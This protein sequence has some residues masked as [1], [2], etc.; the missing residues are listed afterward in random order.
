M[1]FRQRQGLEPVKLSMIESR[2]A[3]DEAHQGAQPLPQRVIL[4][5]PAIIQYGGFM[6]LDPPLPCVLGELGAQACL[7]DAGQTTQVGHVSCPMGAGGCQR[8]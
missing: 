4:G 7:A 2:T 5:T 1:R 3:P 8:R 6:Q